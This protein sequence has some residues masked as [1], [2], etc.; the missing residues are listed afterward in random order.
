MAPGSLCYCLLADLRPDPLIGFL[1]QGFQQSKGKDL[2]EAQNTVTFL[3]KHLINHTEVL[4]L[5]DV[6]PVPALP[7][8]GEFIIY[9]Q[10]N[11][12]HAALGPPQTNPKSTGGASFHGWCLISFNGLFST[13]GIK[14]LHCRGGRSGACR[15]TDV[16]GRRSAGQ[17]LQ[18]LHCLLVS[19][20]IYVTPVMNNH[21][22]GGA[23]VS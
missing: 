12:I 19:A 13:V 21:L 17:Q 16:R 14:T 8:S 4:A 1:E 5:P 10:F 22:Q 15:A 6:T 3:Y 18:K 11:S 20:N 2:S 7:P 23:C 9:G